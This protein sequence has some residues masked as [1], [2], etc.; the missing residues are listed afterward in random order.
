MTTTFA[1][2]GE[3]GLKFFLLTLA[4]KAVVFFFVFVF[5]F[6][7]FFLSL[8]CTKSLGVGRAEQGLVF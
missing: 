3:C 5:C 4:T 1:L 8:H 2:E 6:V 7:F